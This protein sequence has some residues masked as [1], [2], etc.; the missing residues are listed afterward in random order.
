MR[1]YGVR[2]RDRGCCPGHDKCPADKYN[3]AKSRKA[4][5]RDIGISHRIARTRLRAEDRK[6]L[7]KSS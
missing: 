5:A 4:R 7:E 2:R 1:A 3:N 6:D